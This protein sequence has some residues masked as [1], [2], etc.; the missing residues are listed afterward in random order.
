MNLPYH[1]HALG[2]SNLFH[3]LPCIPSIIVPSHTPKDLENQHSTDP[4]PHP[5]HTPTQT[6]SAI[7]SLH[8]NLETPAPHSRSAAL[9]SRTATAIAATNLLPDTTATPHS[10][11][12][13]T[14]P[15]QL[16]KPCLGNTNTS[17]PSMA[18]PRRNMV[19][20]GEQRSSKSRVKS[21]H[22]SRSGCG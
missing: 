14:Q 10:P 16:T 18:I 19:V 21:W 4:T 2:Q 9:S 12:S 20:S 8:K 15:T 1:T 7:P 6:P 17:L 11:H 22:R 13:P 3:F 5:T